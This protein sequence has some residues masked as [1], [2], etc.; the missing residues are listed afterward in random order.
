MTMATEVNHEN[1]IFAYRDVPSK[2]PKKQCEMQ[3]RRIKCISA[4]NVNICLLFRKKDA[5]IYTFVS[6]SYS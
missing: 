2:N 3:N 6:L 1:F 5:P 4:F